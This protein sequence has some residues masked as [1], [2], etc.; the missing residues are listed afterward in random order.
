MI[1]TAIMKTISKVH[2]LAGFM[3]LAH[4]PEKMAT[5]PTRITRLKTIS[6]ACPSRTPPIT[7][8]TVVSCLARIHPAAHKVVVQEVDKVVAQMLPILA[9]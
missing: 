1:A 3:A 4:S 7:K 5:T 9:M 8:L 6:K 2:D